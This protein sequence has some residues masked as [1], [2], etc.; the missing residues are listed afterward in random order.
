MD[1]RSRSSRFTLPKTATGVSG[2]DEITEGGLPRGRTSLV[3][4]SAG[5]GKTL[6]ALEFLLRGAMQYGEPGVLM[7]FEE[8]P[9]DIAANVR[10][11]GFDLEA[12][13]DAGLVAIDHV[14]I[15][16]GELVPAGAYS[17]DALLLRLQAAVEAVG[18]RR[19]VIDTLEALFAG[20]DE[21][22]TLRL[23][24]ARLF[25]WLKERNLTCVVTGERGAAGLTRIGL[26]EYVADC[27]ILLD[28][29]VTDRVSTRHMRI[30][31]YRG[32]S[33]GSNEYPFLIGEDG[34]FV[35]PVTSV[36]LSH[37]ASSERI[38]TGIEAL[39]QM[40]GGR[41]VFRGS[42]ILVSG[43]AGTG[44]TSIAAHFAAATC[45]RGERCLYVAFEESPA[46]L[47]RNM[48]SIGLDLQPCI[49]AGLL[50][51]HAARPTRYG[52]EM[53][54]LAIHQ[55]VESIGPS[56]VIL[57][58]MS[59]LMTSG[60]ALDTQF[61]LLR[62]I[63]FLKGRRI[64]ALFVQLAP[65]GTSAEQTDVGVSSLIDTW[66]LVRDIELGGERNR[67]MYVLKSRGMAHSN[68][69]REFLIT[70]HGIELVP[71]YAGPEGVLTGSLR[72]AQ[73]AR[74]R[75][76]QLREQQDL[77]RRQRELACRRQQ[78]EAQVVALNAQMQATLEEG[79][80]LESQRRERETATQSDQH[81]M[82]QRRHA[83]NVA[84]V[85]LRPGAPGV[86]AAEERT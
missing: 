48:A 53:H 28:H 66:L 72:E 51:I 61:M 33:H 11:L 35:L 10:S 65:G 19:V 69:I 15:E 67:G 42:T 21:H 37:P 58:P 44:K 2:L 78:L 76:E 24:L 13:V 14:R 36:G 50:T 64:T 18:A 75:R 70:S 52:L 81:A 62:L 25:H 6:L 31:K 46:Q 3:C 1:A 45:G 57:D 68:Q 20:V 63:D 43:T 26:E 8:S 23:E 73:E 16:P 30:V 85:P 32:S 12:Q 59:N 5:S 7:A 47:V 4:G 71:V 79:E 80:Q 40:L 60:S 55:L 49:D 74:A 77:A 41:G 22:T 9:A 38:P 17:L 82:A 86:T 84:P 54:L 34:I 83:P 27:V 29:R 56:V 39:D